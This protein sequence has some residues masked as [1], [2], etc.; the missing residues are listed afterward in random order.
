MQGRDGGCNGGALHSP[1]L[2]E[3]QSL[4]VTHRAAE[5]RPWWITLRQGVSS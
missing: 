5:T 2:R 1:G 4:G 3:A